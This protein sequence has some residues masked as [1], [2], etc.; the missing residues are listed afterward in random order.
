MSLYQWSSGSDAI[1]HGIVLRLI[2]IL[3]QIERILEPWM[4]QHAVEVCA[5]SHGR[6]EHFYNFEKDAIYVYVYPLRGCV[7]IVPV[8]RGCE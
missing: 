3:A 8:C 1:T 5:C 6:H 2:G 4:R 7:D